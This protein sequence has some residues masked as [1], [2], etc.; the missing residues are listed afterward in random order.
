[1]A[2]VKQLQC[3]NCGSS[4]SQYNPT[5]QT[6]VCKSCHSY[7]AVG[8]GEPSVLTQGGKLDIGLPAKPV[9][10]GQIGIFSEVK[11][12]VLGRV[13]Y[14]GWDS[15]DRWRWTEWLLGAQ[16]GRM[17]WLSYDKED[18]FVLF[19]KTRIKGQFNPLS[20][21]A[22]PVG[23]KLMAAVRERYPAKI[24]GAEGE[25]TWQ[26]KAGDQLRMVEA[27]LG[28]KHYSMQV[29]TDEIELYEG[30]PLD[31]HKVAEAFGDKKWA[32]KAKANQGRQFIMSYAGMFA[33]AFAVFSLI[34]AAAFWSSGD[35]MLKQTVTLDSATPAVV[36][37]LDLQTVNR[38]VRISTKLEGSIPVNT[39]AEVDVS[40]TDP[41]D[42]DTDI[43]TN[44]F[45]YET[46]SDSDGPWSEKDYSGGGKFVPTTKGVHQIEVALGEKSASVGSV[47][48]TIEVYRNYVET[49]WFLIYGGLN[50]VIGLVLMAMA[51]PRQAGDLLS[52]IFDD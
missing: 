37:P 42:T 14:E 18:G 23:D 4:L 44:E 3:P 49:I 12:I 25:L 39:Y 17:F 13:E 38:P 10:V 32:A 30:V 9:K 20:D 45:W 28:G 50:A 47:K 16:D 8:M 15:E 7:I 24:R 2:S 26:A 22:I 35:S 48:V 36:I 27:A 5:S 40:V 33:L 31:E 21:R 29:A 41:T 34:L 43:F 46:G 1:M 11:C 6:I 52:A 51:H 19:H